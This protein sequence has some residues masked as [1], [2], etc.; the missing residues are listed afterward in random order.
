MKK[1]KAMKIPQVR[2]PIKTKSRIL[3]ESIKLFANK[4]YEGT[5]ISEIVNAAKVNKRMIYH[6]YGDKLGLYRAIFVQI[7]GSY[8]DMVD[9]I[10]NKQLYEQGAVPQDIKSLIFMALEV[11]SDLLSQQQD[12]VRLLMWEALEGGK[13]SKSIWT[14]LRG[15]MFAQMSFLLRQAQT[16]GK[17]DMQFE[18]GHLVV[19]FLGATFFYHAYA[20]TIGDMIGKDPLAKETLVERK[21]QLKL[22]LQK[23]IQG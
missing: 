19:S 13:I 8:K 7:W 18:P 3:S 21:A 2:N 22:M 1:A 12:Y 23:L 11:L 14:E 16:Q 5:S 6:Y 15:P 9:E 10:Y 20:P 4:G 17:M